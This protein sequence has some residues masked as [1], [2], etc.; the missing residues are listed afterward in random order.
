MFVCLNECGIRIYLICLT[1]KKTKIMTVMDNLKNK[2]CVVTGVAQGIG[3]AIAL[4][5]VR[6]G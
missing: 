6:E 4:K 2:V 1:G 3:K 5:M